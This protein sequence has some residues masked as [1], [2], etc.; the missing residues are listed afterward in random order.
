MATSRISAIAW[1]RACRSPRLPSVT[2]FSTIGR[3]SFALGSVVTICSC[4]ISEAA[5]FAN[6][7]LRWLTERFSRR[8]ELPWRMAILLQFPVTRACVVVV[9]TARSGKHRLPGSGSILV[10]VALGEIFDVLRRPIRHFHAE[11]QAHG[12]EHFLDLVQRLAAEVR[13]AQHLRLGLLDEVADIDDVVV[14]QAV[15]RADRKLQLVDLL[16]QRRI[17]GELGDLLRRLLLGRLVEIDE[18]AELV[19]QDA[20]REGHGIL[21]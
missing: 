20:R 11:M 10:F 12:G 13:G 5:R 3:K 8:P 9:W 7:D 21:A 17:E 4:S 19:L 18:Q 6:I 14:L 1:R 15:G 16:K 2:S